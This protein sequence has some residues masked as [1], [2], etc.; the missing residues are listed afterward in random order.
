MM[1]W[2]A[3]KQDSGGKGILGLQIAWEEG[4]W[5]HSQSG[6]KCSDLFFASKLLSNFVCLFVYLFLVWTSENKE[7]NTWVKKNCG[8]CPVC[9]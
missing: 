8:I 1:N 6:G 7:R 4:L 9:L 3:D 5:L 2:L